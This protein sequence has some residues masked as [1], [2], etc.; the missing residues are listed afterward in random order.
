MRVIAGSARSLKL[1]TPEGMDTR[2]TSDRIKETL[3]N[4]LQTQISGSIVID[5]FAGSGALGIEAL[6][7]GARHAYFIEN[8]A[9]A[10]RCIQDNLRFTKL[11]DKASVLKQDAAVALELINEKDVDLIVIDPPYQKCYEERILRQ[12]AL[13]NYVST[14]TLIVMETS[15]QYPVASDFLPPEFIITREKTYKTNRHLFIKRK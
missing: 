3:F 6:S 8:N 13:M 2:P 10:Y 15:K 5:I 4:I 9:T 12:L 11:G 7:R 14:E 1:V